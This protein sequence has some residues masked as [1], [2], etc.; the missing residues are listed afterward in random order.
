MYMYVQWEEVD[1][2]CNWIVHNFVKLDLWKGT[3]ES[4][5]I[6][7]ISQLQYYYYNCEEL[8][9]LLNEMKKQVRMNLSKSY[10]AH[11]PGGRLALDK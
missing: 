3:R 6:L 11:I 10:E 4:E 2:S 8:L 9:L 1:S 7:F 5:T